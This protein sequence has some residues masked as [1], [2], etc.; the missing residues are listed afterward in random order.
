MKFQGHV[1]D[2]SGRPK[3]DFQKILFDILIRL[4][5]VEQTEIFLALPGNNK[6]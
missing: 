4:C 3:I 5:K 6:K 2:I 1:E